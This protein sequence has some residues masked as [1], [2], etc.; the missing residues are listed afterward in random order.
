MERTVTILWTS[1]QKKAGKVMTISINCV[2]FQ[3][4]C[5][6]VSQMPSSTEKKKLST[7]NSSK[8]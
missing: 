5:I 8:Q 2:I 7:Q 4:F 6:F 1:S 3:P